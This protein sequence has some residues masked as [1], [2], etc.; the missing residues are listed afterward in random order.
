MSKALRCPFCHDAL[1][2]DD[3]ERVDCAACEG[4]HHRACFLEADGCAAT[5]C[6]ARRW[7]A[8]DGEHHD[9]LALAR[10]PD[11]APAPAFT[12]SGLLALGAVVLLGAGVG[13]ALVT[14]LNP[15]FF[16][17]A[18][19]WAGVL[20]LLAGGA[21]GLIAALALAFGPERG[22]A[23]SPAARLPDPLQGQFD[24][25]TGMTVANG[26]PLGTMIGVDQVLVEQLRAEA[27]PPEL[28]RTGRPGGTP[29]PRCPDCAGELEPPEPDDPDALW[30]C[31]HCG[32]DLVDLAG[33]YRSAGAEDGSSQGREREPALTRDSPPEA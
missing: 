9:L 12:L 3:A 6:G 2:P 31:Y 10:G 15:L 20:G 16:P 7:R 17:A 13:G 4:A 32:A 19:R 18:E 29:P 21:L 25:M 22:P 11:D 14:W 8:P 27:P 28:R 23:R 5:G 26:A 30:D 33:R 24:P 1:A